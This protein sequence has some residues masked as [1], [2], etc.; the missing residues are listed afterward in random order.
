MSNVTPPPMDAF[1]ELKKASKDPWYTAVIY[2]AHLEHVDEAESLWRVPYFGQIV[3]IGT[4]EQNFKDRKRGHETDSIR[5]HKVLGFHAVIDMHG[6][7][8]IAWRI[9]DSRSGPRTNM[10]EWAN[11]E[12]TRLIAEHGGMLR[13]MDAKLDQTLN[14]T[15]GG[16]WGDAATRWAGIDAKRRRAFTKFKAAMER[17][18]AEHNSAL[19]SCKYVDAD[20]YPLGVRVSDFRKGSLRKGMPEEAKIVAWAESLPKW[21]W[22]AND[23]DEHQVLRAQRG[24]ECSKKSFAKFKIAMETY[25]EKNGSALV[26]RKFVVD[27]NKYALGQALANF[28]QGQMR[29]GMPNESEITAWAEALPNWQWNSR[30]SDEFRIKCKRNS[31]SARAIER[32]NELESAR[33]IA[34]PFEMSKKRR[35]EMREASTVFSEHKSNK[36]L[37]MISKDGKTIRRVTKQGNLTSRD[38]V[39]PV[40][41]SE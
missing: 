35:I 6:T 32:R 31:T 38:T 15:K 11:S 19:V 33:M 21:A 12:E 10:Q 39:G 40:V 17:Y 3:R 30:S 13:D 41:D 1:D 25:V 37:Y 14:L 22:N 34:V 28:R 20:G 36:V 7:D 18:V 23:T 2:E 24:Q 8:K 4:A 9:V 5:E 29:K 27:E 26:P 16:Q